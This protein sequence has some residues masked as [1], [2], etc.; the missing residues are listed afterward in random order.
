ML[1]KCIRILSFYSAFAVWLVSEHSN[2]L[3][4]L[5]WGC[6][7]NCARGLQGSAG[8]QRQPAMGLLWLS[9]PAGAVL[10]QAGG[11]RFLRLHCCLEAKTK[12]PLQGDEAAAPLITQL[13]PTRYQGKHFPPC[14]SMEGEG[15]KNPTNHKAKKIS[16]L[17]FIYWPPSSFCR[18]VRLF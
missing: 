16:R 18:S 11:K 2:A 6:S 17:L 3:G 7:Q 15:K 10:G 4:R 9:L 8:G 1:E 13:S 5:G 14:L 12:S